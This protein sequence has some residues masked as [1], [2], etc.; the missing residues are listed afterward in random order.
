METLKAVFDSGIEKYLCAENIGLYK[1]P[2]IVDRTVDMGFGRE[3]ND[4]VE[5]FFLE[6]PVYGLTVADIALYEAETGVIHHRAQCGKIPRVCESVIA[7]DPVVGMGFEH[8][9]DKIASDKTGS[10]G[11]QNSHMI[12]FSMILHAYVFLVTIILFSQKNAIDS[13]T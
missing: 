1:D 10:A 11:N 5:F 4:I 2:G 13:F 3:M 8:I 7:H 9:E 6:Q 12:P